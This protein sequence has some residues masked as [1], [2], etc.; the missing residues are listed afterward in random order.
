[1][2]YIEMLPFN[3]KTI[4]ELK[5]HLE[6]RPFLVPAM[7]MELKSH[8]QT[9]DNGDDYIKCAAF[10]QDIAKQIPLNSQQSSVQVEA[11]VAGLL[12]ALVE[13][14]E[15]VRHDGGYTQRRQV[16]H[17]M[18]DTHA[19]LLDTSP[20]AHT[21]SA[22]VVKDLV[23][24][25]A[26][27]EVN[28]AYCIDSNADRLSAV[29]NLIY[30]AMFSVDHKTGDLDRYCIDEARKAET[31]TQKAAL[32]AEAW[33]RV[34]MDEQIRYRVDGERRPDYN[35]YMES[36]LMAL[37][38][39][40]FEAE[41]LNTD[42]IEDHE[43]YMLED[44]ILPLWTHASEDQREQIVSLFQDS[45]EMTDANSALQFMKH[46]CAADPEMVSDETRPRY[47]KELEVLSGHLLPVMHDAL[48]QNGM[49]RIS[50]D[51][52]GVAWARDFSGVLTVFAEYRDSSSMVA[53]INQALQTKVFTSGIAGKACSLEQ[54]N[55]QDHY[56]QLYLKLYREFDLN[57]SACM[58]HVMGNE[59]DPLG[60]SSSSE[61]TLS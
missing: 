57:C 28:V 61:M 47:S 55:S 48:V 50:S 36:V 53:E 3:F 6:A 14:Y 9:V 7:L 30:D 21:L 15:N 45:L 44:A 60:P 1:M 11:D 25:Y 41:K 58:K 10:V 56:D 23:R 27:Y 16:L 54:T 24:E 33:L 17:T 32:P 12:D 34:L 20:S 51:L 39:Y 40:E 37:R 26:A 43:V 22:R 38:Q 19:L 4:D 49:P 2:E 18:L 13:G 52:E 31:D 5:A 59:H 35:A 46:F 8:L 29:D 42:E